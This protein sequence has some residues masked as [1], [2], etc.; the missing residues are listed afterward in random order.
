MSAVTG[1][2]LTDIATGATG[3]VAVTG[4][5]ALAKDGAT[6]FAQGA[7]VDWDGTK[8]IASVGTSIGVVSDAAASA[9]ATANVRLER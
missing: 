7:A 2:A 5:F 1:V 4:T 3:A 6:P 8:I 9:D